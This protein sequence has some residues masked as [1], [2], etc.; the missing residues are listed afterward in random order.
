[1]PTNSAWTDREA[2]WQARYDLRIS[3]VNANPMLAHVKTIICKINSLIKHISNY[4]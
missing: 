4:N 2:E 1:M 3:R